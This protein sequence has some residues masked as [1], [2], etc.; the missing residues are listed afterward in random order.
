MKIIM[1][2]IEEL[3]QQV[4]LARQNHRQLLAKMQAAG[5][6]SMRLAYSQKVARASD[7]VAE[8]LADLEIVAR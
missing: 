1:A 2:T 5:S 4:A 6:I 3:E 8:L 7:L